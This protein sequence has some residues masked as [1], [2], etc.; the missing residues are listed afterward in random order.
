MP[1]NKILCKAVLIIAFLCSFCK[2]V[3]QETEYVTGWEGDLASFDIDDRSIRCLTDGEATVYAVCPAK[4][5]CRWTVQCNVA[6]GS[7]ATIDIFPLAGG[8]GDLDAG[9]HFTL[10]RNGSSRFV[11]ARGIDGGGDAYNITSLTGDDSRWMT[12]DITLSAGNEWTVAVNGGQIFDDTVLRSHCDGGEVFALRFTGMQGARV[13]N[14]AITTDGGG[15]EPD[16]PDD[17]GGGGDDDDGGEGD[18]DGAG[19]DGGEGNDDDGPAGGSTVANYG[20]IVITEVM[21]DPV[22]AAGLPEAEYIEL[23]NATDSALCLEG[24]RLRYGRNEY[25]IDGGEIA[26]GGYVILT[27]AGREAEWDSAGVAQRVDMERFPTLANTGNV[28]TVADRAGRLAAYTHYTDARYGDAFKAEGGFSLERIDV[29][30]INDTPLNWSASADHS[31]GTPA[32]P[33]SVA[34]HCDALERASFAYAGMIAPDTFSL[35]FTTPLDMACASAGGWCRVIGSDRTVTATL[36]DTV[37]MATVGI[38]LSAPLP[39][40]EMLAISIDGL[41][42]VDGLPVMTPDTVV[43]ALP[44]EAAEGDIVVNE[45][46]F[47]TDEGQSEFVEVCN[48]TG[49]CIDLDGIAIVTIGDDGR[50]SRSARVSEVSRIMP[51]HTYLAV[52]SDTASLGLVWHCRPWQS[53]GCSLP[54]LRDDGGTLAILDAGAA[55]LDIAVYSPDSYPSTARPPQGISL[56]KIHPSMASGNPANWL[57]ATAECGYATPGRTNSQYVAPGDPSGSGT[58]GLACDYFTPDGDGDNDA[59][60]LHYRLPAGGWTADVT[61]Y[62]SRGRVVARPVM[63][64]TLAGQGTIVWNG[65][66][67]DGQILGQGI[68]VILIHTFDAQGQK[69]SKK[70]AVAI[71]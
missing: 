34:G 36:P 13:A 46:L 7:M 11:T 18:D 61:V 60:L 1:T 58:F 37:G 15:D 20:D 8:I 2:A 24:W 45:I 40:D 69:I 70:L 66:D 27:R 42:Q 38:V 68:Y 10:T 3:G 52:T 28:L 4:P 62:D 57:P 56:E 23:L 21:A 48:V 50:P 14:I 6:D 12:I 53:A 43:L 59:A 67:D 5:G 35:H 17:D 71:N 63:G 33:N 41:R 39:E 16:G 22:G 65:T 30:N 49:H 55:T 44:R 29:A 9:E 32:R 25:E 51:P 54:S 47:D 64:E 19:D 26:P 31:G